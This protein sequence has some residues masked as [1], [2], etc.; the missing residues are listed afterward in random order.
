MLAGAGRFDEATRAFEQVLH[1]N[2]QAAA[3]Q[4]Q[5]ARIALLRGS[6]DAAVQR[7]GTAARQVPSDPV[8]RL[9][10]VRG[11]LAKRDFAQAE[12]E[13]QP[14]VAAFPK[15]APVLTE[16][17]HLRTRQRAFAQARQAFEQALKSDADSLP[18]L[19][20]LVTLEI[21]EQR[22]A[23]AR[24]LVEQRLARTPD[25]SSVQTLAARMYLTVRDVAAAERALRTAI[26][27]DPRNLEAYALLGRLY[28][29]Q[30][31]LDQAVAEFEALAGKMEK[32][33]AARTMIGVIK[34]SQGKTAEARSAYEQVLRL[35]PQAVVAANN[36]AWLY[37]ES[38]TS[39]D[40]AVQLAKTAKAAQ[41]N[42][43]EIDDT[44]GYVYLQ[45]KQADL[46]VRPLLDAV[47]KI[48]VTP[49]ITIAS[50][51]PTPGADRTTRHGARC[52]RHSN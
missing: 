42:M 45:M 18:A 48:R 38:S 26:E 43:A 9:V 10:L 41:P 17:G 19:S 28:L 11:H 20:G 25:D 29:A 15:S 32:P 40:I 50:G 46:A 44:L 52:D 22:P 21:A 14:L 36:L 1:L 13:L 27:L 3:A 51:W 30:R 6:P 2:P 49:S 33:I 35:D 16:L 5:L 7:A 8:A 39:L 4:L 24:R 23:A 37:A 34:Q 12:R 31:R 47:A